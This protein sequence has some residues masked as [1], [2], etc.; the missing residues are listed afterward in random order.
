V[1]E[2]GQ[3]QTVKHVVDTSPLIKFEGGLQSVHYVDDGAFNWLKNRN[4]S[5]REMK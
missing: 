2:C 3:Q 5:T 4:Y 1:C